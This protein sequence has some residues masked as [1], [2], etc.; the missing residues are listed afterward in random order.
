M[1]AIQISKTGSFDVLEYRDVETP[2]P[3]PGHVLVK[4][5]SIAVNFADVRIRNGT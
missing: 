2:S 3:G 5:A 1:K 4:V